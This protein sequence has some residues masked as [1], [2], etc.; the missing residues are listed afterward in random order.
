M[1]RGLLLLVA[2]LA[3][4]PALADGAECSVPVSPALYRSGLSIIA[5]SPPPG[6]KW[7]TQMVKGFEMTAM[8][9]R[10]T[11][12][13]LAGAVGLS[14]D[15]Q[16]DG[17]LA[18]RRLNGTIGIVGVDL[19][20][21]QALLETA[22][23]AALRLEAVE[24]RGDLVR[25][26]PALA[27]DM[28][29]APVAALSL[30]TDD[31]QAATDIAAMA[32]ALGNGWAVRATPGAKPE[33]GGLVLDA[34]FVSVRARAGK[35]DYAGLVSAGDFVGMVSDQVGGFAIIRE[36]QSGGIEAWLSAVSDWRVLSRQRLATPF[37]Y[38]L[39]G[40]PSACGGLAAPGGISSLLDA[41]QV[42]AE[43]SGLGRLRLR[44]RVGDA[45]PIRLNRVSPI[46]A[47]VGDRI[48]VLAGEPRGGW[49]TGIIA[50]VR[51]A[52]GVRH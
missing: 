40:Y 21:R 20:A 50:L 41:F 42:Q 22:A 47:S 28:P 37:G 6:I 13:A 12:S 39:T 2:L 38:R 27:G 18:A 51:V 15:W 35:L 36:A 24:G 29:T 49:Q 19:T 4:A 33:I 7:P 5:A 1:T 11:I 45:D 3:A 43:R 10:E 9:A 25:V 32:A 17:D 23:A 31:M 48:L 34:Q 8:P 26:V 52:E 14:L 44:A 16:A 30:T 46:E